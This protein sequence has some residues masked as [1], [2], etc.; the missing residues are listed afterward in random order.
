MS[1]IFHFNCE[2]LQSVIGNWMEPTGKRS[3]AVKEKVVE[4]FDFGYLLSWR[5]KVA[6]G[7]LK[8]RRKEWY[9]P[10]KCRNNFSPLATPPPKKGSIFLLLRRPNLNEPSINELQRG[11]NETLLVRVGQIS[12]SRCIFSPIKLKTMSRCKCNNLFNHWLV[13]KKWLTI[14]SDICTTLES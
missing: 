14:L 12:K 11:R 10:A 4:K 13:A 8:R 3:N 9:D 6:T 7:D 2:L 5:W 1:T